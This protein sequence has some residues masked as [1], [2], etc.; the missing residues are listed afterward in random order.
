[1]SIPDESRVYRQGLGTR[2]YAYFKHIKVPDQA[3]IYILKYGLQAQNMLEI[4]L[5][6]VVNAYQ[7]QGFAFFLVTE[8]RKDSCKFS[9]K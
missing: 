1:M 4:C 7:I 5:H 9:Y 3:Q 6:K 2:H 8:I